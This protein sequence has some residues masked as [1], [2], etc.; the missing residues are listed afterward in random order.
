MITH[1]YKVRFTRYGNGERQ[2]SGPFFIQSISFAS[3]HAMAELMVNAMRATDRNRI[4]EVASI[5][6]NGLQGDWTFNDVAAWP[7]ADSEG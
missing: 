3:A 5:G 4:Y 2:I 1:D 7:A 6:V